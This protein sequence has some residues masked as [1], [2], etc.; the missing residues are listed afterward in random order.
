[1]GKTIEQIWIGKTSRFHRDIKLVSEIW[2]QSADH[3]TGPRLLKT[4]YNEA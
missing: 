2:T 4:P 1:M 3:H